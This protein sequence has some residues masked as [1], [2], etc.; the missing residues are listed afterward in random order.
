V[1]WTAEA[2][3][4]DILVQPVC[5]RKLDSAIMVMKAAEGPRGT[6]D[7]KIVVGEEEAERVRTIFQLYLEL[8]S[9]TRLMADLLPFLHRQDPIFRKSPENL[10]KNCR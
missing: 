10:Q 9:L 6:M 4:L 5:A 3:S 8:G 7:R 1:P 2:R